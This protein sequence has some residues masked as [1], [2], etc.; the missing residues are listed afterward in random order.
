MDHRAWLWRKKSSEKTVVQSDK[1]GL[2]LK[3]NEKEMPSFEE[4]VD[5]ERCVENLNEKLA[6]VLCENNAKDELLADHAKMLEAANTGREKAEAEVMSLKQEL[7]EASQQRVAA[8]ER[9]AHLNAALKDYM[10]QLSSVREEQGQ[11]VHDAI[12]KTSNEFEKAHKILEEKFT[13]T[14]KRLVNITLDNSH[15]GKTLLVKEKL[16]EDLSKHM[17]RAESEFSTLMARLDTTEKENAFLKY[18]FRMLEKE[19]E[20]RNEEMEFNRQSADESHKQHLES[21]KKLTKLESECQRL[22][23]LVRKR[24]PGPA[25]LT[26]MKSEVEIWGRNHA[27]LRRRKMKPT[28]ENSSETPAKKISFLIEQLCDAEEENKVLKEFLARRDDELRS[29]RDIFARTV[30]K[31]SQAETQ[32][33]ELSKVQK[34]MELTV[35][36]PVSYE[37][38]RTS[39][40]DSERKMIGVSDMSLMDDFAE[41]E[42]LAIVAVDGSPGSPYAF[43][44]VSYTLSDPFTKE[45]CGPQLD[46]IGKE[47]VPVD[48]GPKH[49]EPP[50]LLPISGY[51]TWKSPNTSPSVG[52]VKEIPVLGSSREENEEVKV[53]LKIFTN[54]DLEERL[55]LANVKSEALKDQLR[56]SRKIMGDLQTEVET[57]KESK[58]MIEDQVENQKLINE[59]LDTQLTA[60]KAKLNEALQKLSSLEVELEDKSHCCKDFESTCLELQL[61]LESVTNKEIPRDNIDENEKMLQTGWEITAASAKLAECQETIFNL[62]K[63]LKALASPKDSAILNKVFST[64]NNSKKLGQQRSSLRDRMLAED[65]VEADDPMSPKTKEVISTV[66]TKKPSIQ[67]D[68]SDFQ[69]APPQVTSTGALAI[70]PSK[71]TGGGS[72]FLRKLLL[73]RKR[74]SSKKTCR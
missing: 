38:S 33:G 61:Q 54:N 74:G 59:D 32:M 56:E 57:L 7:D 51:I 26:K 24:L 30:S 20:I 21:V 31:L 3:Q 46:S 41:M 70:V 64:T 28:I 19:L 68:N 55:T 1:L 42:K 66:E 69:V 22:R 43:S 13:E 53:D 39:S 35:C 44:D 47:L 65:G 71:K 4:E 8:N 27:E 40:F 34:S 14:S 73:R 15:L 2:S 25:A 18:E 12:M 11:R 16:I 23:V 10:Q 63:Q 37:L 72:S 50:K 49:P 67:S 58:T 6:S 17:S 45:S 60:A 62:G 29:L 52:S 5:L 9:L 48:V 36:N